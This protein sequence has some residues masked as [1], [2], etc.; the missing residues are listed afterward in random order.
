MGNRIVRKILPPHSYS[1]RALL[2]PNRQVRLFDCAGLPSFALLAASTGAESG[3]KHGGE[4]GGMMGSWHDILYTFALPS[5]Y[6]RRFI[7]GFRYEIRTCTRGGR[8]MVGRRMGV[9]P[10]SCSGVGPLHKS[11]TG[12]IFQRVLSLYCL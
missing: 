7:L 9:D 2:L 10:S 4:N 11:S 12:S 3:L 5:P 8:A 1:F 6:L